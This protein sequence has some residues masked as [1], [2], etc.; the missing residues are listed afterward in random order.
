MNEAVANYQSAVQSLA[1]RYVGWNGSEHDDLVQEGLI[2]VWQSLE[3]GETPSRMVIEGRM[4][5]WA[6]YLGSQLPTDYNEML[7]LDSFEDHYHQLESLA[8]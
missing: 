2:A 6:R 4:K 3:R 7:P 8:E 5:N 1:F